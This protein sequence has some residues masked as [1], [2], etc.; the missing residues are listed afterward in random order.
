MYCAV[1]STTYSSPSSSS[2]GGPR[3]PTIIRHHRS[4]IA[5]AVGVASI[6]IRPPLQ[7]QPAAPRKPVRVMQEAGSLAGVSSLDL[8]MGCVGNDVPFRKGDGVCVRCR[9]ALFLGWL[10][11]GLPHLIFHALAPWLRPR[12]AAGLLNVAGWVIS[13]YWTLQGSPL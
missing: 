2:S 11:W 13:A 7:R 8:E 6:M 9:L 4:Q 10:Q 3:T 1:H 5:P 12:E